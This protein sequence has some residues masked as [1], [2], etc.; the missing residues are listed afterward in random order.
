MGVAAALS[1]TVIGCGGDD[2]CSLSDVAPSVEIGVANARRSEFVP[3]TD[4]A[5]ATM[6]A[7]SQGGF[8]FYLQVRAVGLCPEGAAMSY[9]VTTVDTMDVVADVTVAIALTEVA[10]DGSHYTERGAQAQAC[11]TNFDM[12]DRAVDVQVTITDTLDQTVSDSRRLVLRCPDDHEGIFRTCLDVCRPQG[13]P[14]SP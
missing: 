11:P 13:F 7:G 2:S 10:V 14:S 9:Q 6:D 4:G 12:V 5:D 8:H 1:A 3:V